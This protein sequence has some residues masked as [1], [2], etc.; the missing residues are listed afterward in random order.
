MPT[1][2]EIIAAKKAKAAVKTQVPSDMSNEDRELEAAIDRIDPPGKRKAASLV[3]SASTPLPPADTAQKAHYKELRSLGAEDGETLDMTPLDARQAEAAWHA[4]F[5]AFESELCLM[6]DPK[7]PER[8]WI[9]VRLLGQEDWPILLK[10]LPLYEH[11]RTVRE[12]PF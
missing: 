2:A 11:P 1:I 12:G 6:R 8:A 9:A 5:N 7:D 10:S 4:A 3:L